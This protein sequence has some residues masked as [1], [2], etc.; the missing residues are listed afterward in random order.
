M[1]R[2]ACEKLFYTVV[3]ILGKL[4]DAVV[5]MS[6]ASAEEKSIIT[7]QISPAAS[8]VLCA[9]GCRILCVSPNL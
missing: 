1:A 9:H 2:K 8:N 5:L 7:A 3:Y 4:L 6:Y